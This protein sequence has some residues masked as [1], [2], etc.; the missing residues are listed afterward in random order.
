MV[1]F[2]DIKFDC[3]LYNGY[4]PCVYG[5]ECAGCPFYDPQ[6]PS[7]PGWFPTL[8]AGAIGKLPPAP[9]ILIIKTG[10]LGDV[11]RTTTLLYPIRRRFPQARITWITA[12]PALP[13]LSA[14]SLIDELC[15]FGDEPGSEL[16]SRKFDLVICLEKEGYPLV[17]AGEVQADHKV[18]YSPTPWGTAAIANEEARYMLVLGVSDELKFFRNQKSYPEIICEASGLPYQRDPYLLNLTDAGLRSRQRIAD[19]LLQRGTSHLPVVG[20]NT[21]CGAVFRTKQWTLEGWAATARAL[22]LGGRVNVLL[23]GGTAEAELNRAIMEQV[24]GV[25]DTGTE[26]PLEDFFGIV[27]TCDVVVTSDSLGMHVAIAREKYVVALFG[28]TSHHEIDLF[29]RGEKII[30]DFP[31]SPCY[32]KTCDKKPMCMEAM[33]ANTVVAAVRRGLESPQTA[34]TGSL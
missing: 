33:S 26:N 14:N 13:L 12:Q 8:T 25:I 32:L 23:M 29:N 16:L 4:K 10:A 27:D 24:P 2:E 6:D 34:H 21:G 20:L 5:N 22:Q 28:S 9:E 15:A 11:L 17:F 7:N 1:R 19:I 31:C 30:T 18:G 3:R